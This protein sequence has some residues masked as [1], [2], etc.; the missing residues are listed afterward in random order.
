MATRYVAGEGM[1]DPGQPTTIEGQQ[2][3]ES[4]PQRIPQQDKMRVL[5]NTEDGTARV[6]ESRP[7][8]AL[9]L[10]PSRPRRPATPQACPSRSVRLA[11]RT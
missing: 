11:R 5:Y 7:S 4:T 2:S 6:E 8:G 1:S 9:F 10:P 3:A